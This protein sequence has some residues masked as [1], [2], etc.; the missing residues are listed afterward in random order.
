MVR[1]APCRFTVEDVGRVITYLQRE[2]RHQRRNVGALKLS[3]LLQPDRFEEDLNIARVCLRPPSPSPKPTPP[4]Q[5]SSR[6]R[7]RRRAVSAAWNKSVSSRNASDGHC[8]AAIHGTVRRPRVFEH[9]RSC[10]LS[11]D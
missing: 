1:P 10:H 4:R 7:K 9:G 11:T 2:I 3:H 6:P 8:H 5:R